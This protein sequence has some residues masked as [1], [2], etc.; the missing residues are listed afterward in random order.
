MLMGE[1]VDAM[2]D[3]KEAQAYS[4]L[5][6][7]RWEARRISSATSPRIEQTRNALV[8]RFA[9]GSARYAM[10]FEAERGADLWR[11]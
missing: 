10:R 7:L 4:A 2:V 8:C 11:V 5:P 3:Y 6:V 9:E 1:R